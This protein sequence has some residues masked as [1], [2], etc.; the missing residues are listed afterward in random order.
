MRIWLAVSLSVLLGALPTHAQGTLPPMAASASPSFE[1]ATIRPTDPTSPTYKRFLISGGRRLTT[2]N[3]TLNDLIAWGY[4][5]H[6]TQIIGGP[7]WVKTDKYD[8]QAQQ[9][10]D[11]LPS[12]QQWKGMMQKLLADRFKL[13][14]H[15][16]TREIPVY[17]LTVAKSGPKLA[18]SKDDPNGLPGLGVRKPGDLGI[19]NGTMATLAELLQRSVMDRPVVDRTGLTG[20]Y[21]LSLKWTPVDTPTAADAP[22]DLYTAIQEELGLKLVAAKAL[23]EVFVIDHVERPSQN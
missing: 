7:P 22:P 23:D 8:V 21:D 5:L 20:K 3:T 18:K 4:V 12:T 6:A 10:T 19:S 14:F 11:N 1:V 9:G 16:D 15:R 13:T 17:V 2:S